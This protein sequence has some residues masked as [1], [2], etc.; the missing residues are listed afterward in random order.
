MYLI[1]FT[2]AR[3]FV[4][5]PAEKLRAV[6]EA[7][8]G[9]VIVFDFHDELWLERLPLRRPLGAPSTWPAGR[10]A[11]E[12]WWFDQLFQLACKSGSFRTRHARCKSDMIQQAIFVIKA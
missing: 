9:E 2:L 5:P 8:I 12:P 3:R 6:P 1:H 11:C 7:P 10:V 4:G